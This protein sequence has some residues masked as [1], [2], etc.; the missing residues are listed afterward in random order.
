LWPSADIEVV[1]HHGYSAGGGHYT[2]AVSRPDVP[3]SAASQWIHFDDETV[4]AVPT[5]Q[6]VVSEQEAEEVRDGKAREG[7]L[8]IAGR[9]R[10]AYL[11]FYQRVRA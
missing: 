1:Y 7:N 2:V 11:L 4:S 10:C 9:E 3:A 6:V 8:S 5:E